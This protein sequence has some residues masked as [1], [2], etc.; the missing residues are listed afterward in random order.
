MQP[1]L[2]VVVS[3]S[4][5]RL[6]IAN[7][8]DRRKDWEQAVQ[9]KL[10]SGLPA[11]GRDE[12]AGAGP[13]ANLRTY[14]LG[15]AAG[16]DPLNP[17]DAADYMMRAAACY[18]MGEFELALTN[19]SEALRLN[20][21]D[22]TAYLMRAAA[23]SCCGKFGG[24]LADCEQAIRIDPKLAGAYVVRAAAYCA[25]GDH[26]RAIGAYD[27]A[28]RF[29]PEYPGARTGR[30]YAHLA[31]GRID[32][33]LE[34]FNEV[35]RVL[36]NDIAALW[37]RGQIYEQQGL[38]AAA[39]AGYRKA[40]KQ[41]QEI[42]FQPGFDPFPRDIIDK[43]RAKLI[44]LDAPVQAGGRAKRPAPAGRVA[45]VIGNAA[46]KTLAPLGTAK[47]DAAAVAGV[48]GR[49]GFYV[50]EKHDLGL[51]GMHEALREFE[52]RLAGAAWGVVYYAG[53]AMQLNGQNWLIPVDARHAQVAAKP[54]EAVPLER[55]LAGLS[56]A[57]KVRI[58]VL[59][60]C[61][62]G[63]FLGGLLTNVA[64][65]QTM[66]RGLAPVEPAHGEVVFFSARDGRA[67]AGPAGTGS[68][69]A[70]TLVKQMEEEGLELEAF[71]RS[72][73]EKVRAGSGNWQKPFICGRPPAEPFY[74]RPPHES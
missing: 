32:A 58:A 34:D 9:E 66:A 35:L 38:L 62:A 21:W 25:K 61:E 55:V 53:H 27:E 59:D 12:P 56:A 6:G 46:Y 49:L 33:A 16:G 5:T 42:R 19:S 41:E 71:F 18:G 28:L 70:A 51:A 23:F 11:A 14:S 69:F 20:P 39:I 48:L 24:A 13:G 43:M 73:T 68:L 10:A 17:Q 72:V 15:S 36:P 8:G 30:G 44:V 2:Q 63:P 7:E 40:I 37:G 31:M 3:P 60:T 64:G 1:I 52:E 26:G 74:F 67:V 29:D 65:F 54:A 57:S 50:I 4:A 45:L 47:S 22:A